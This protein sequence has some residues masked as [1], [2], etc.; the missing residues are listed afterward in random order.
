MAARIEHPTL[1]GES[2]SD[3]VLYGCRCRACGRASFPRQSFGCEACG[4]HGPAMVP[5]DFIARGALL[6]FAV[7]RKHFGGDIAAPFAVGEIALLDGPV[8]R[9]TMADGLDDT[10]F[11]AGQAVVGVLAHNPTSSADVVELRFAPEGR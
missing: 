10:A 8:I 7:V 5:V 1:Y 6:S 2:A 9:C 3:P 4:A 11:Y